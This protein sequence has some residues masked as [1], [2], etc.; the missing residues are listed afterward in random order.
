MA[1]FN[2]NS[3]SLSEVYNYNDLSLANEDQIEMRPLESMFGEEESSRF[4]NVLAEQNQ[5][6]NDQQPNNEQNINDD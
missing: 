4:N 5:L 3:S 2:T 1:F 6:E